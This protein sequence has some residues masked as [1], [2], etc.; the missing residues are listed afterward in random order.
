[1]NLFKVNNNNA[2]FNTRAMSTTLL[3]TDFT[4]FSG[5]YILEL[6][7][8]NRDWENLCY[9]TKTRQKPDLMVICNHHE[10]L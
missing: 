1:M 3:L 5:V 6:E 2:K 9:F 10:S 4:R 8:A 7:Q